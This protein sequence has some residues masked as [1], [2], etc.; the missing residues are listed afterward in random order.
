MKTILIEYT[1]GKALCCPCISYAQTRHRLHSPNTPA[2][3]ISTPCLGYCLVGS[4][5]P[6]AEFI[7]GF[8]QRGDIRNRLAIDHMLPYGSSSSVASPGQAG[9][10]RVLESM[11]SAG[12]FLDDVW[13]HFFCSSCSLAQED[14]EVRKWE[15]DISNGDRWND[16]EELGPREVDTA[17][18]EEDINEEGVSEEGERLLGFERDDLRGLRG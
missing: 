9:R 10:T 5:F 15:S 8:L 12:G 4:C 3:V 16:D 17:R 6:G 7:F 11:E 1:V 13:R 18:D 2:P 14:R